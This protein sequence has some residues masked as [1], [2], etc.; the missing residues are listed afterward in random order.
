[1]I[2]LIQWPAVLRARSMDANLVNLVKSGGRTATGREQRVIGDAGFWEV[3]I[4]DIQ[5]HSRAQAD[6]YNRVIA[7]LRTG[8]EVFAPVRNSY[9]ALG[10]LAA[11]AGD[12][13]AAPC[14]FRATTLQVVVSGVDVQP[15]C[16][17]TVGDRL[18]QVQRVVSGPASPA[19]SNALVSDQ[20]WREDVP[21]FDPPAA[22]Q[23]YTVEILPPTRAAYFV[24]E[25]IRFRDLGVRACLRDLSQG[26]L[27]LDLGRFARPSLSLIEAI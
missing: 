23:V 25:P 11:G 5:I 27:I 12:S 13:V 8:G 2:E 24:G 1:M 26:P 20:P 18:Y 14:P 10:A 4:A 9:L 7:H 21:W 22:S 17:F 16:R 6:A 19:F 15:G 3:S